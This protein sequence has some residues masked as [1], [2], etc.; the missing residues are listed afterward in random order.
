MLSLGY[1]QIRGAWS[2][3]SIAFSQIK[4]ET[5]RQD[6]I[7]HFD[8]CLNTVDQKTE[9]SDSRLDLGNL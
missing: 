7:M 3:I 9:L 6:I 1:C 5:F 8:C 2:E 4:T